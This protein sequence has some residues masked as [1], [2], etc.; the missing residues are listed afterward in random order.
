LKRFL[1]PN[2]IFFA[3]LLLAVF[4]RFWQITTFPNGLFPDEAANGLDINSIFHGHIQPFYERG[5]GREALFFYALAA[6]VAAFGRGP[7]QHHIV[8][9]MFGIAEIIATYLLTRRM[10]G[11]RTALLASLFMACSSYAVMLNRNAF[12][13]NTIPLFTT[14]TFYFIVK[15]FQTPESN[16]KSR[17]MSAFWAGVM[18]GL[19]FY[20]YISYRMMLPLIVGMGILLFLGYRHRAREIIRKY[21][22]F[23]LIFVAGFLIAFAWIG[24]YYVKHPGAFIGRAGQ[25]SV[26]NKELNKGDLKGTIITVTKETMLSFFTQGDLNWRHNVSGYPFLS[27]FLSPFFL[28]SLIYFTLIAFKYLYDVWRQKI[29]EQG[30]Y[31]TVVGVWF[32]FMI[33][34]EITT[35][36][37]IPHGLRLIGVIPP[38]FILAAWSVNKLWEWISKYIGKQ[39][40]LVLASIFVAAL[41]SYNYYLVF[42]V[43]AKSPEDYYAFRSDLTIVSNYLDAR[44]KKPS[45]YLVLDEF[46]VQTTDYLTTA[47]GVPYVLQ[48]PA[49]SWQL[50]LKKG[51]QVVFTQSTIFDTIKF[52]KDTQNRQARERRKKSIWASHY[53]GL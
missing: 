21:V 44:N 38:I 48:D 40:G 53:D 8:T 22:K 39:T 36:E 32:W 18:F 46:S 4:F 9:G 43:A 11:K 10:F 28:I 24:A 13:A 31:I 14:L 12:R 52:K 27:P 19:G 15:F 5:N 47:Y 35:A 30:S 45:T 33:V 3:I 26:F 25:V 2:Y 42:Q 20:T 6:S 50:K 29:T 23:K 51:D 1:K 7:W 16:Y 37:A 41:V 34:P 49:T 17:V